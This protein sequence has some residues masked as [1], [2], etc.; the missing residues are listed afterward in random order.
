MEAKN[1]DDFI[2][3]YEKFAASENKSK[4]TIEDTAAAV[5]QFHKFLGGSADVHEVKAENLREYIRALQ[6]RPR[7]SNH[8]TIKPKDTGLSPHSI[9]SYVRSIRAFWSWLKREDFIDENP[10]E[11]VKPPKAPRKIVA[12][13][14]G[15]QISRLVKSIPNKDSKGYR[16][17][18]I[19]ITLYG[20]GLRISELLGLSLGDLNF[21]S[22]Q[23]KVM[24][25]GGKERTVFMSATVLKVLFKYVHRWRPGV[26][27]D[28][29]FVH[30][31]GRPLTRFYFAHRL[32][33][34]G[35][36]AGISDRRCSPHVLRH[37]FAV[38]YLR[39]GAD[40]FTL[41]RILG[42]STLEMTRHYAEIS[43]SDVEIKQK[44]FSPAEKLTVK[45]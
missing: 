24:G 18:T 34:Y 45:V 36:K 17:R 15:E 11:R 13:L 1:L 2:L 42:H 14:T 32:Q 38:E 20:T 29:I 25:K 3:I 23:I 19:V 26:A 44:T 12:T 41:Q 31:N 6:E 37:T 10:M 40:T 4:R 22:G 39:N 5:R 43:N 30:S 28:Y 27:T 21:D 7:W 33:T 16:D 9:A 35:E 8:P